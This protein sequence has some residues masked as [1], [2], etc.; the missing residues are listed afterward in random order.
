MR[1]VTKYADRAEKIVTR[2]REIGSG[3]LNQLY[4]ISKTDLF[5]AFCTAF[6]FGF[7]VGYDQAKAEKSARKQPNKN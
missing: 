3:E 2:Q 5:R 6:L 4:K 1:D 7:K